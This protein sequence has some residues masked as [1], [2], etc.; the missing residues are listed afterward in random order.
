VIAAPG[1]R[2]SHAILVRSGRAQLRKPAGPINESNYAAGYTSPPN[3]HRN[4]IIDGKECNRIYW[5]RGLLYGQITSLA[6][7][8]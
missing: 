8:S 3:F 7:E 6:V 4:N 5:Y 2:N 1:R